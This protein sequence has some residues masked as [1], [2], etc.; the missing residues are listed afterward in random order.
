[1]HASA[2]TGCQ[3]WRELTGPRTRHMVGCGVPCWQLGVSTQLT[4]LHLPQ[5]GRQIQSQQCVPA[6]HT[7]MYPHFCCGNPKGQDP[8]GVP[9]FQ[10]PGNLTSGRC[11]LPEHP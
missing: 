7:P 8:H 6:G 9:H 11:L 10:N 2:L 3:S 5:E 1:M 4:L